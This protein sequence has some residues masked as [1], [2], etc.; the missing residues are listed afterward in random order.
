MNLSEHCVSLELATRLKALGV[1]QDSYFY[2]HNLDT[3][4]PT[5]MDRHQETY[6]SGDFMIS[7]FTVAELGE[8]LPA[9]ITSMLNERKQSLVIYKD[10]FLKWDIAYQ[11]NNSFYPIFVNDSLSDAMALMLIY[12]LEQGLAK[13]ED[14]K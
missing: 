1:K 13:V 12:L 3:S 9:T 4:Y 14:I 5:L 8:M 11:E 7:A 6:R 2:W 10:Y